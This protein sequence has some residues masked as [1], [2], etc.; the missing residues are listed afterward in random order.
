[1]AGNFTNSTPPNGCA[2]PVAF[3]TSFGAGWTDVVFPLCDSILNQKL[4]QVVT[5][6]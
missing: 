2:L 6:Q 3:I 4:A 5:L 1:M